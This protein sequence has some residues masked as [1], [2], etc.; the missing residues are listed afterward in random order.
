MRPADTLHTPQ[1][2]KDEKKQIQVVKKML[3]C[4]SPTES[5]DVLM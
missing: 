2:M 3:P 4:D 5:G 1:L